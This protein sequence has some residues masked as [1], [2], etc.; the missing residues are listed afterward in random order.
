MAY[1]TKGTPAVAKTLAR[2]ENIAAELTTIVAAFDKVPEQLALEQGRAVFA[3]DTGVADAYLVALPA[4]LAAYTTGLTIIMKAVN[5]NTGAST[6]NV[7]GLGVK[8]I[9]R[10]N[11]DALVAGDIPAGSMVGLA[12]DGTN[13]QMARGTVPGLV[14]IADGG[15]GATTAGGARTNLGLVIGTD[16][17]ANLVEDTTPQLGGP[18]DAN[19]Q[20]IRFSKGA[21]IASASPLVLGTDGNYFDVTG[22]TG[23]SAITVSADTEFKLQ[24]DGALTMTDGASLDLAGANIITAAGDRGIFFATAA[25]TVEMLNYWREG[26]EPLIIAGQAAMETGTTLV[27]VV[28][29]GRQH[30]HPSAAKVYAEFNVGGTLGRSF[31]VASIDDDAAGN[32]GVNLTTA[33]SAADDYAVVLGLDTAAATDIHAKTD[34]RNTGSIEIILADSSN[35]VGEG[36]VTHVM[37][38][39]FGDL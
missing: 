32:F 35:V 15:T 9:K 38:A 18:L 2:A 7:D 11:G 26:V 19:S 1:Y 27:Q 36:A 31:N 22:T 30:N 6:V 10:P 34:A 39:A 25:N 12:Y 13:F 16:V 33:F 4:T 24:F 5:V 17:L 3:T 14:A 29:P 20:P 28:T 37:L 23:F 8:S 21:D